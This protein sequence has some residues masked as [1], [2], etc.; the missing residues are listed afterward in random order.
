MNPIVLITVPGEPCAKGRP[1]I[2]INRGTGRAMAFTPSKTVKAESTIALF[3]SHAMA[4]IAMLEGP[5]VLEVTAYRS[6][7]MPGRADAK[8]GT[9]ALQQWLAANAGKITPVSKPDAD[10]YLK[11]VC[12]ALNGVVFRDDAQ[13]VSMTVHKRFSSSPRLEITVRTWIP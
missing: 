9:K 13:I 10:N 2:G 3:A 8:A 11:A 7:G 4:G 5:L 6:K 1:R 12:D